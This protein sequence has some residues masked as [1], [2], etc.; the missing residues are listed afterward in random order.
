M[1]LIVKLPSLY[2]L[3]CEAF[4]THMRWIKAAITTCTGHCW[5]TVDAFRDITKT[6]TDVGSVGRDSRH[7]D[8][9]HWA[10][11]LSQ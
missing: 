10:G 4:P 5:R 3:G 11:K 1:I 9:H 2:K 8:R 7:S 6:S